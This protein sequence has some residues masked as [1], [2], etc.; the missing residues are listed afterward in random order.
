MKKISTFFILSIALYSCSATEKKLP[1]IAQRDTTITKENSFTELFI[2]SIA[3]WQ[4]SQREK[5]SDSISNKMQSFYNQRNHQFAWFFPDGLADFAGTFISLQNDY[6][7]YSGDSSIYDASL[8]AMIDSVKE[9]KKINPTDSLVIASELSLTRQFFTYAS[10]AYSGDQHI[11]TQE[12]DWFIPR[13]K[14]DPRV[15]L[16]SLLKNKGKNLTA[17]EPVNRQYNLLKEQLLT[18]AKI[19]KQADTVEIK[20]AKKLKEGASLEVIRS[21]K[22]RLFNLGDLPLMDTTTVFDST[23]TAAVT[24]FQERV[25]LAG[26]GVIDAQFLTQLNIP[27]SERM[28]TILINMERIRWMPAAPSTDYILVNIPEFRMHVYEKGELAFNM[29][30]VVG[31][32]VHNTVI[33]SGTLNQVVFS[34]YWNI[35]SS[36]LKN[37]ILPGIKRQPNYLAKH[38]MEWN[39]NS[40]RQKPGRTNSLGLVKFL[41]PNNYNIYFH[42]TPSKSL[43]KEPRRA[44]SHGCIRLSEPARLAEFLLRHDS[45]WDREKI[46]QAMNAGTEKYV[47]LKGS[48]EIPVF[49]GYFTSWVDRNGHLNFRNDVYGHDKK[50]A[51][52][53]FGTSKI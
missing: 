33:F 27:P 23:L 36:I 5:L 19:Q 43:F 35:P 13:R 29:V 2:D 44:F 7:N 1:A 16:D 32:T 30:V 8:I 39:G 50:M 21:V 17:Y 37:E 22:K 4:F 34:P 41:F 14:L 31:S 3:L 47:R 52:R 25:G 18:Y 46:E 20:S 40:V 42:D 24:Q 6:I 45:Q 53:L 48:S 10:K 12:L 49:I 28:R 51:E 15:F 38:N 9:I 11:N 26:T